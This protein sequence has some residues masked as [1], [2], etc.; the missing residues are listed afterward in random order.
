M[1]R[2]SYLSTFGSYQLINS[3]LNCIVISITTIFIISITYHIWCSAWYGFIMS[4]S[5]YI[6]TVTWYCINQ[7]L[8]VHNYTS[9]FVVYLLWV[10]LDMP[11]LVGV[12]LS[13]FQRRIFGR[14][15]RR[16][17]Y[18]GTFGGHCSP[19]AFPLFVL[20]F[21][22]LLPH[23]ISFLHSRFSSSRRFRVSSRQDLRKSFCWSLRGSIGSSMV[24]FLLSM[25]PWTSGIIESSSSLLSSLIGLAEKSFSSHQRWRAEFCIGGRLLFRSECCLGRLS[26]VCSVCC[27]ERSFY[28]ERLCRILVL[29]KVCSLVVC[30]LL[31]NL[32]VYVVGYPWLRRGVICVVVVACSCVYLGPITLDTASSNTLN[33]STI[34]FQR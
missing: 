21:V 28:S 13:G 23:W 31:T 25:L 19:H 27:C 29:G 2:W 14:C 3:V 22:R 16:Q 18:C 15:F 17:G 11:C 4:I 5:L 30:C 34:F 20:S 9:W 26:H 12:E 32:N 33:S 7:V 10:F 6:N 1:V 24:S 8:L